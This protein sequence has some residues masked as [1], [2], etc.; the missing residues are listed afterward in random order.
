MGILSR[1]FYKLTPTFYREYDKMSNMNYKVDFPT[2]LQNRMDEK[3]WS[4]SDMALI[5]ILLHTGIRLGELLRLRLGDIN[6]EN[7]EVYIRPYRS[8]KKSKSR[9]VFLGARTRQAVWKYIAKQQ[10]ATNDQSL[11]LIEIKGTSV[12]QIFTRIA[13]NANVPNVHP[14]KFRHTFAITYLRNHG[15]IFTL[16]RLLGH[17]TLDMTQR[18]LDIVKDDVADAHKYASPV[19]NWRL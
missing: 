4:Q 14:H 8:S 17:A 1:V 9:T 12:R 11:P 10:A 15:D 16:K 13:K 7:G 19:D 5:L 3:G 2:W 18:Y 6:L